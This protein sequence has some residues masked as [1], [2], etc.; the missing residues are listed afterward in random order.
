MSL[1]SFRRET[2]LRTPA[3]EVYRLIASKPL[4]IEKHGRYGYCVF[5]TG[6]H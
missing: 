1:A 6:N 2:G 4:T 5:R 3:N